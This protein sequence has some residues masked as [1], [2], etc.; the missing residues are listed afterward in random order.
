MRHRL[1]LLL[2]IIILSVPLS[3]T[4]QEAL[5]DLRLN[6]TPRN[7]TINQVL[8]EITLQTGF[9]FTYNAALISG[10]DKVRFGFTDLSLE[11][12]LDL[13][14]KDPDFDY[15]V[16]G[17]NVVIYKKN[18]KPPSPVIV[19]I[20]RSIIQGR[21]VDRRSGKALP[22]ATIALHGTSLGSIS[23]ETGNFAFKIPTELSD[24]ILVVSY[25]GYKNLLRPI[26]YPVEEELT[27]KLERETIPLQEVIIRYADPVMVLNEAIRRMPDN[28]MQKPAEM[29]AYYRESV[30]KNEHCMLFSEA[31]LDVAKGPY[32]MLSSRDQVS[33]HK[34]R[35]ITDLN[36]EDTVIIKLR[37][38]IDA[39]LNLDIIKNQPD[40][41]MAD[42]SD[43]YDLDFNDVM[44]YGERLVYVIG[45]K[46]K[47]H[48]SE[49]MF[50]GSIYIDQENLA[51]L[52]ADFEF[53][54]ELIHQ[55]P[56]I[57]LVSSSPRIRIRPVS[58]KYHVDYRALNGMYHISQARAEVELK[59][60]KRRRWIGQRY[61]ISIEMAITDVIPGER[62][63]IKPSD[64]VKPNTILSDQPFEFDPQFWGI[65][66]TIEPEATLQ[67]SLQK[68]EH[69][70]QEINQEEY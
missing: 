24:P 45:F 29:T 30:K 34:G 35:K 44:S 64:R 53:N 8:D 41:L 58:A 23:N 36:A 61:R 13:L 27:I 5:S 69:N 7:R 19:E 60:R 17:R 18:I 51:I 22:Y 26:T 54:P 49:L 39:S 46:Q 21:I 32:S 66:N 70:I 6:L 68:I 55:Q 62:K 63:K 1:A 33:I 10:K 2:Q 16:I 52:A 25:M 11:D 28:Y 59:V 47:S 31:V 42:F 50:R 67:E 56:E 3:M 4:G 40:F 43:Y 65:Y 15:K 14:L 12:A 57:F 9:Y 37:S 20:N 38:G 48:I